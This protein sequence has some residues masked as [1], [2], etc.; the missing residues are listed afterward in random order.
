MVGDFLSGKLVIERG[1]ARDYD[2][3]ARF[4]YVAG[5]PG[6]WAG[7]WVAKY[8]EEGGRIKDEKDPAAVSSLLVD[9]VVAIA[10]LSWPSLGSIAREKVLNVRQFGDRKQRAKWLNAH[11]RT[12]SRVVVHPQFR[13][14]GLASELVRRILHEC[15]TRYVETIAAMGKVHPFFEHAGMTR[16]E[17]DG[18]KAY[19]IYDR[20]THGCSKNAT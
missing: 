9:R 17:H 16:I 6:T 18:V 15:P 8:K 10:V 1:A 20:D 7:V 5:R 19:F 12:I 2:E 11:V 14:V 3:L 13:G 4:H